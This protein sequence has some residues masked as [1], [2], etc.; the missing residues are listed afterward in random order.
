MAAEDDPVDRRAREIRDAHMN[1]HEAAAYWNLRTK[2]ALEDLTDQL[3]SKLQST[4]KYRVELSDFGDE[5]LVM[6]YARRWERTEIFE[7]LRYNVEEFRGS[8]RVMVD[9]EEPAVRPATTS[10]PPTSSLLDDQIKFAVDDISSV[11]IETLAS[12]AARGYEIVDP[13][14]N[15]QEVDA[16]I[17]RRREA[18]E[19]RHEVK[20]DWRWLTGI[21]AATALFLAWLRTL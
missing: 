18:H 6:I 10:S 2:Q 3:Q 16:E 13:D 15:W 19:R 5:I 4:T 1:T 7:V 8:L 17:V 21:V 12:L 11:T 9:L 14:S 20:L